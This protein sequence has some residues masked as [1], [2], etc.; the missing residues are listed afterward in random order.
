ML[1]S[2]LLYGMLFTVILV[3]SLPVMACAQPE[4]AAETGLVMDVDNGQ[5]LFAKGAD[6]K[7]Y[8]AS[9]TKILTAL[10]A[11]KNCSL[12]ETVTV[13]EKA[14]LP[15]GSAVGL[16][17]GERLSVRDILYAMMLSS[18]NDGA[19]ALAEHVGGSEEGFV[20]MMNQEALNLGATNSHFTNPHGLPDPEHYTTA[21]DLAII[22]RAAMQNPTFR[23]IVG[24]YHY[25]MER[26]LPKPVDGIPQV[27]F[28][29]HNRMIWP[30]SMFSYEGATGIK[31]G[32]TVEA[33]QCL[34][35]SARRGERE[36][37][38]VVM[39]CQGYD[40][41][42][43]SKTLLDYGFSAFTPAEL[44]KSGVRMANV[45]VDGGK[46]D[47]VAVVTGKSFYYNFPAAGKVNVTRKVELKK[48][49]HA[50]VYR[51]DRVGALVFYEDNREIGRV[52]LLAYKTVGASFL[53]RWW[54][55]LLTAAVLLLI[56]VVLRVKFLLHRRKIVRRSRASGVIR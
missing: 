3:I 39:K 17:P 25:R 27:D 10:V 23:K 24:T 29:N 54:Y 30:S 2:K 32:Y 36:L 40:V 8:P 6:Q 51:E 34:V 22:A 55:A 12:N 16:Q 7:M 56:F 49:L 19:D 9:T 31:T 15:G 52:S 38:S 26:Y 21:R 46:D 35:V 18:A 4:I 42:K 1:N 53:W 37:L 48:D 47:Q 44:V 28:V 5:V 41:Y 43:D 50:P 13:S 11:L 20:A 33:G 14:V 45:Q